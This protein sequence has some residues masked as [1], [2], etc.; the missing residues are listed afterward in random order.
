MKNYLFIPTILLLSIA[1]INAKTVTSLDSAEIICPKIYSNITS[2]YVTYEL[3]PKC[4][5]SKV[6]LYVKTSLLQS[7]TLAILEKPPF[8]KTW[9]TSKL[10]QKDQLRLQFQYTLFHING[11]TIISAATPHRWLKFTRIES[12]KRVCVSRYLD[13]EEVIKIDGDLKEWKK[14][15][16]NIISSN[17]HFKT[18]WSSSDFYFAVTVEDE[19]ITPQDQV[20]ISLNLKP[21]DSI[22]FGIDQRIFIF[23]PSRRS[24]VI[25]V[26]RNTKEPIQSDSLLIRVGEEM[27]WRSKIEGDN[28]YLEIRIPFVLL[29]DLEFPPPT[30]GFDITVIDNNQN[31]YDIRSWSALNPDSRQI[32]HNWGIIELKQNFFPLKLIL[33][34][35]LFTF[36]ILIIISSL[37][38][39][40]NKQISKRK[41]KKMEL[42][43]T[44]KKI[45]K[46][47]E[48]QY[49][50]ASL[51]IHDIA[52]AA[53]L[54]AEIVNDHLFTEMDKDFKSVLKSIRVEKSKSQLL[55]TDDTLE[56]IG[57]N[58]GFK[59]QQDFEE[60]FKDLMKTDPQ[61]WR[62]GRE[63]DE[64]DDD[65][66]EETNNVTG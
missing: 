41:I 55:N 3:N 53:H 21:N 8:K 52:K 51:S 33:L 59:N 44:T 66:L 30:F 18:R 48:E 39:L 5:V 54:S 35:G 40:L 4:S 22:F 2:D 12:S 38:G 37:I 43:T 36:I 16:V 26:D 50:N 42:S 27:E 60:C 47:I 49:N 6:I 14:V 13:P 9:N 64:E 1:S 19:K 31:N 15:P 61:S 57:Y 23:G 56:I 28:Y 20:E 58:G 46:K 62:E 7:D 25:A 65:Q 11:D 24:F 63:E 34:I 10:R 17:S 32:K 29:S 45:L